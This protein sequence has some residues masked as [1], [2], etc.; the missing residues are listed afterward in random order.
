M[1]CLLAGC[2]AR[3]GLESPVRDA[4]VADAPSFDAPRDAPILDAPRDTPSGDVP[5][6]VLVPTDLGACPIGLEDTVTGRILTS[7]DDQS[8]LFVNGA[9]IDFT[10]RVWSD[11]GAFD[12]RLSRHPSRPNVIAMEGTNVF[13]I[14]GRDRGVLADL[15]VRTEAGAQH[16]VTDERFRLALA[17]EA[18][19]SDLLHDDRGWPAATI[20]ARHG[21]L[22]WGSL[23]PGSSDALWLWSYDSNVPA[24]DKPERERIFLRRTFYFDRAGRIVDGPTPCP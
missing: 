24:T 17:P 1:L 22:P 3:S 2:G 19:W 10:P 20:E 6:D 14:D 5:G 7:I 8:R 21:E 16:L 13:R 15:T 12:V 9:L 4:G 23:F 11:V 18:G